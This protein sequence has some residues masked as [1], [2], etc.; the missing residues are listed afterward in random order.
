MQICR[1]QHSR[2]REQKL[3]GLEVTVCLACSRGSK[4]A[5]EMTGKRA[6]GTAVGDESR[7]GGG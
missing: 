3:Q 5:G 6:M 1:E 2:A 7:R 4:E